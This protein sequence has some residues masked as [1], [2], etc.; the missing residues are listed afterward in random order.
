MYRQRSPD[1]ECDDSV[2]RKHKVS[3]RHASKKMHARAPPY[4]LTKHLSP[5]KRDYYDVMGSIG[6]TINR[7]RAF[8]R[9][10]VYNEKSSLR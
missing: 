9:G 1:K 4:I 5:I 6:F 3:R 2:T 7:K 10:F 8:S